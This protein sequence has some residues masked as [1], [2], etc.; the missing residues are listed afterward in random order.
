MSPGF[1]V[2]KDAAAY[3]ALFAPGTDA[4]D[5]GFV[6][7]MDVVKSYAVVEFCFFLICKVAETIP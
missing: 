4:V 2:E 1:V 5:V 7:A 3:D 6:L